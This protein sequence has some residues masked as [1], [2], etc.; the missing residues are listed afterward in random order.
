MFPEEGNWPRYDVSFSDQLGHQSTPSFGSSNTLHSGPTVDT[1]ITQLEPA[2]LMKNQH[3]RE[4]HKRI[5]DAAKALADATQMN[6]TL[7]QENS[8]LKLEIQSLKLNGIE[9]HF[10]RPSYGP[11]FSREQSVSPS[12]SLSQMASRSSAPQ[13]LCEQ[14]DQPINR[15]SQYPPSILWHFSDCDSDPDVNMTVS[16]KTSGHNVVSNHLINLPD[17]M[18]RMG[19]GKCR[20][21]TWYSTWHRKEWLAAI[22]D[23]EVQQPLL[24]LCASNWKANH[25]LGA[26]LLSDNQS[27]KTKKKRHTDRMAGKKS[28]GKGKAQAATSGEEEE[29][30]TDDNNVIP[31]QNM[32]TPPSSA[33]VGEKRQRSNSLATSSTGVVTKKAKTTADLPPASEGNENATTSTQ[34]KAHLK[35]SAAASSMLSLKSLGEESSLSMDKKL[36]TGFIIV[37]DSSTLLHEYPTMKAGIDLLNAMKVSPDFKR[38][39]PSD[40]MKAF[41]SRIE[42]SDPN[43]D[44][45]DEDDKGQS[46]GHYQY[47]GGGINC[48]SVM[49]SWAA[50]GNTD[51]VRR[52]IAAAI[53]TSKVAKYICKCQQVEVTSYMSDTYL[54]IMVEHLWAV[55]GAEQ[56]PPAANGTLTSTSST[57]AQEHLAGTVATSASGGDEPSREKTSE[58]ILQLLTNP[59]LKAWIKDHSIKV[60][61]S[62]KLRNKG[63]IIAAI[64]ANSTCQKPTQ[65]DVDRIKKKKKSP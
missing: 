52:L 23:F 22:L 13:N 59:E 57:S 28:K 3:Y 17:P 9:P 40:E 45:I 43:D 16:N 50:V 5:S 42:V 12:E 26:L 4:L 7:H 31:P 54:Q 38:K 44:L 19:K 10:R 60:A 30:D 48:W 49:T 64:L 34:P 8:H 55:W 63:E 41:L 46:W 25:M 62:N 53:R 56:G 24:R 61:P 6:S 2:D 14:N 35:Y 39:D 33:A 47:T 1:A 65:A 36:D 32:N 21:K 37:S 11:F 18:D 15:P 29:D 58:E 51:V 27:A 20:T